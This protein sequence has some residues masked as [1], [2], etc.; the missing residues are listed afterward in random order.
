MASCRIYRVSGKTVI[1]SSYFGQNSF[2][3]F[4]ETW[5]VYNVICISSIDIKLQE[6]PPSTSKFCAAFLYLNIFLNIWE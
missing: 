4:S 2:V 6:D 3:L 1:C 5:L